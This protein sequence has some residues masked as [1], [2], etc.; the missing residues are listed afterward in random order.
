MIELNIKI[1]YTLFFFHHLNPI[2][3]AMAKGVAAK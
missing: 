1:D 2:I 3:P